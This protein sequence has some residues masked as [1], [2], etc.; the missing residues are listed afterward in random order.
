MI[1]PSNWCM[2][3]CVT[4]GCTTPEWLMHWPCEGSEEE[5]RNGKHLCGDCERKA[6]EER[7]LADPVRSYRVKEAVMDL[8]DDGEE[9][10]VEP[11]SKATVRQHAAILRQAEKLRAE[12][13]K[14]KR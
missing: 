7:C 9:F 10:V 4:E 6:F 14:E 11:A 8:G 2:V 12:M 3:K 13:A 1:G 5:I